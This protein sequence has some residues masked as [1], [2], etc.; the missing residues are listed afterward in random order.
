MT[1]QSLHSGSGDNSSKEQKR[2]ITGE[3]HVRGNVE[4]NIA[5]AA[6]QQY[7]AARQENT[8]RDNWRF[9]VE[10]ITLG[11]VILVAAVGI[12][13]A[14]QS[15]KSADAAASAANTAA[16]A[17]HISEQAYISV[18]NPEMDY[19]AHEI[20]LPVV[21]TGHLASTAVHIVSHL[22]VLNNNVV[23]VRRAFHTN[24]TTIPPGDHKSY[25]H[26]G[27]SQ[28]EHDAIHAGIQKIIVAGRIRYE[29]GFSDLKPGEFSYCY[30]T[31]V[32]TVT[33]QAGLGPCDSKF[34]IQEIEEADGDKKP[35][36]F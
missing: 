18:Q 7:K 6:I 26:M 19:Q 28:M 31:L 27:V 33:D 8:S 25:I 12:F 22:V 36:D 13:Q 14:K 30:Q 32:S 4:A 29:T 2:K 3:I 10:C 9:A 11:F 34:G 5:S 1:Q 15:S 35:D 23:I 21:D 16:S 20:R 24:F 17:L